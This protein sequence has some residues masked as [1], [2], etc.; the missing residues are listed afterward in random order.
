MKKITFLF[1]VALSFAVISQSFAQVDSIPNP[2]FENW[3]SAD[4]GEK[5]IAWD[6]SNIDYSPLATWETITKD[7][8]DPYSGIYCVRLET[9]MENVFLLGDV[10]LPGIIT[11]GE[12]II[13]I[14]TQT[15]S[16]IGGIPFTARPTMLKGYYKYSPAGIDSC[17][18]A[19]GLS[20]WNTVNN[21][22][23]TIGYGY[24]NSKNTVTGWTLFEIPIGYVL[25]DDPDSMNIIIMS[26]DTSILAI[27]ST[28]WIDSLS[29]DFAVNTEDLTN[30][31]SISVYPNPSDD[32]VFSLEIYPVNSGQFTNYDL[33][34]YNVLGSEIIKSKIL[35]R[36]SKIDMSSYP[37]GIY[38]L[39]VS[40]DN[41]N[42]VRK[43]VLN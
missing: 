24:F 11:L 22:R 10:T 35:N 6:V 8:T 25:P 14:A 30:N 19:I 26:S 39:K 38:F 32:G 18:I 9:V 27:G 7:A 16:V 3:E 4:I 43:I 37:K 1:I 28:L 5:P 13:D 17:L 36:K 33:K 29:F 31:Q 12:F 23:D 41:N 42:F 15:A 34:I 21:E 2:D 40:S 20:K